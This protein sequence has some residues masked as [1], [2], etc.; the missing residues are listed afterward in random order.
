LA[1]VALKGIQTML[2]KT[3]KHHERFEN[4]M[5]LYRWIWILCFASLLSAC[6]FPAAKATRQPTVNPTSMPANELAE[7]TSIPTL[8]PTRYYNGEGRFSLK[9]PEGW[10]ASEPI[11]VTN[12]P[13]RP[14]EM[15]ILGP[16]TDLSPNGGPGYSRIILADSAQWTVEQFI[17]SQCSSCPANPIEGTI[18]DGINAQRTQVGGGGVPFTITWYFVPYQDKLIGFA[19]HDPETL[20]PLEEVIRSIQFE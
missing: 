9:L 11:K 7:A 8:D 19:I 18:L 15:I 3:R 4:Q 20:A 13:A 10:K 14:Y 17:Q 1:F 6:N 12:D 2:E 5:M 16:G